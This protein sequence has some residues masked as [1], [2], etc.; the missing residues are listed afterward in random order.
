LNAFQ[1]Q[2]LILGLVCFAASLFFFGVTRSARNTWFSGVIALNL[3][4]LTV[5]FAVL[6]AVELDG[7]RAEIA[8]A[9][10][11]ELP[12]LPSWLACAWRRRDTFLSERGRRHW[13]WS[14][15]GRS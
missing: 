4:T 13:P 8:A 14:R 1:Q 5:I 9:L 2:S 11:S 15:P 12:F 7:E 6:A 3:V 10:V